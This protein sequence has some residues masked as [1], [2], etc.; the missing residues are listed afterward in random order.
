[1]KLK[2]EFHLHKTIQNKTKI[3]IKRMGSKLKYKINLIFD[4]SV[5]V[6]LKRKINIIKGLNKR[7]KSKEWQ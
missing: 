1:M 2:T 6:K 7:T 4:W 3:E 5:R